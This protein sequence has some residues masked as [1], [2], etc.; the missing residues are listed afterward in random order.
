MFSSFPCYVIDHFCVFLL[1]IRTMFFN[2]MG[3]IRFE[4]MTPSL[5]EKC[6][7]QLSYKPMK[8]TQM[9]SVVTFVGT[10]MD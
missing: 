2:I 5:S 1:E 7:N 4:L 10:L 9:I 6:S 8:S 3:L